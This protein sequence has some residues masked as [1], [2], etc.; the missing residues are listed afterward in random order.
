MLG[1]LKCELLHL[2]VLVYLIVLGDRKGHEY[3]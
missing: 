3:I 1:K 2:I